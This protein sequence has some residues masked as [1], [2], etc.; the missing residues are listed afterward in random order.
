MHPGKSYQRKQPQRIAKRKGM[1]SFFF[2][3]MSVHKDTNFVAEVRSLMLKTEDWQL[4]KL[5]LYW[6]C[7]GQGHQSGC[8]GL[9]EPLA[10][11]ES[12]PQHTLVFGYWFPCQPYSWNTDSLQ[13]TEQDWPVHTWMDWKVRCAFGMQWVWRDVLFF[14]HYSGKWDTAFTHHYCNWLNC[15]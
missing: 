1:L 9:Q 12:T 5:C 4:K 14:A 10:W 11:R 2:F 3:Y 6:C 7:R 13:S 15:S 8:G